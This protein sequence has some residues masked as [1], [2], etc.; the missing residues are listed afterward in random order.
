MERFKNLESNLMNKRL[1]LDQLEEN[2]EKIT[3]QSRFSVIGKLN[4]ILDRGD[5][6]QDN[7]S[8]RKFEIDEKHYLV[9]Q[10]STN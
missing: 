3:E 7:D 8:F 1:I 5:E 10:Q 6:G 4:H 2:L 9:A